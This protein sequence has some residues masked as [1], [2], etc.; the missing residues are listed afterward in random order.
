MVGEPP[1]FIHE[2]LVLLQI[3]DRV[4]R[5]RVCQAPLVPP[6]CRGEILVQNVRFAY[7]SRRSAHVLRGVSL[8]V[9]FRRPKKKIDQRQLLFFSRR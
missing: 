1:L 4:P 6:A 5:K 8:E 7:P 2:S 9:A 3:L